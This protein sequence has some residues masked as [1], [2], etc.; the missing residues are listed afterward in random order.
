[1]QTPPITIDKYAIAWQAAWSLTDNGYVATVS[2]GTTR[3]P[4]L[5]PTNS[6]NSK[7]QSN[8]PS[9]NSN[10]ACGF[11]F[12]CSQTARLAFFFFFG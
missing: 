9:G 6:T 10:A 2:F 12:L 3:F 5:M 1:L 8:T 7:P 11:G 4:T